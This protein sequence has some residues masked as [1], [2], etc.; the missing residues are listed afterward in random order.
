[1]APRADRLMRDALQVAYVTVGKADDV[2]EWSGLN[3]HIRSA[4]IE[5]GCVVHNVDQ[6]GVRYPLRLRIK[7]RLSA[8]LLGR[9]YAPERS[10]VMARRWAHEAE[11]RIAAAGEVDVIVSTGTLPV[12]LLDSAAP[13]AIWTDATFHSLRTIYPEF[14]N[15][16]AASI[17]EGDLIERSALNRASLICYSSDW[18]A[19]DAAGYYGIPRRKIRVIPFGAN[20]ETLFSSREDAAS[21]VKRRDWSVARFVFVG[22]DWRRKGGDVAVAIVRRL[23][24]LGIKSVLSVVGCRPPLT[25]ED[26]R[27]VDCLGFLSKK[28]ARERDLLSQVLLQ[29]HFL[30]L[31]T[32]ADCSALVFNEGSAFALPSIAR[33]VGGLSNSVLHG[34]TGLLLPADAGVEAYCDALQPLL[35]D[36]DRYAEMCAAAYSDYVTRVNWQVSGARFVSELQRAVSESTAA[37]SRPGAP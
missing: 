33:A 24:E 29:S 25:A 1:M 18:A 13:V 14:A 22:V 5:H 32:R 19:D 23:N 35:S 20:C 31:P 9:T 17:D 2:H 4:M 3:A 7:R 12:A 28:N 36:R 37:T 30:L 6:L 11:Q 26:L 8:T 27:Y 16:S 21:H 10:P 34:E 15:Y